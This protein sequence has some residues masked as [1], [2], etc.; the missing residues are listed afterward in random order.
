MSVVGSFL[1]I[2]DRIGRRLDGWAEWVLSWDERALDGISNSPVLRRLDGLLVAVTYVG[3]GYL[4][5]I[6]ALVLI[7]FGSLSDHRNVLIG[8]GTMIVTLILSQGVKAL[9]ARPRP[10]FVRQGFHHQFLTNSS[11]PSNHTVAAFA[12]AYLVARL[13]PS[14]PNVATIYVVAALIGLSRVYLREHFPLDVMGGAALGTYMAHALFPL[15]ATL[16][17]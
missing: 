1:P 2:L 6:L 8:L 13:Y 15:F 17:L 4:W 12:M 9:V 16:V 3:Y 11:F 10:R 7:L 5:G 14:W